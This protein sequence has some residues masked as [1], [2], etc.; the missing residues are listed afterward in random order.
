MTT[1]KVETR[2]ETGNKARKLRRDNILPGVMYSKDFGNYN[3][4]MKHNEFIKMFRK[5]D[6]KRALTLDLDGESFECILKDI[7]VDPIR[8]IPRHVDF[9]IQTFDKKSK[10]ANKAKLK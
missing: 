5:L 9:F 2:T 4:Q 3:I 7:D 8:D 10:I 1:F 6:D